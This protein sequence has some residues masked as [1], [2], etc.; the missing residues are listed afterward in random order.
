MRST[1]VTWVLFALC[2][3]ASGIAAIYGFGWRSSPSACPEGTAAYRQTL[4]FREYDSRETDDPYEHPE[5]ASIESVIDGYLNDKFIEGT[6][7]ERTRVADCMAGNHWL[8]LEGVTIERVDRES[9][10]ITFTQTSR[11][12][13]YNGKRY[14]ISF[15]FHCTVEKGFPLPNVDPDVVSLQL[16]GMEPV[17]HTIIGFWPARKVPG[18]EFDL[19]KCRMV[20]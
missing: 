8:K 17:F 6:P 18:K 11:Y 13:F 7:L 19:R 5:D 2:V 1:P 12:G 15:E 3:S 20:N 16:Q 9:R 10:N 14:P 4:S